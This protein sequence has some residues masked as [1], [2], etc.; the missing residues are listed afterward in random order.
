LVQSDDNLHAP[1]CN[2]LRGLRQPG[3]EQPS[4]CAVTLSS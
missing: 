3:Q 1:V 2:A 4:P